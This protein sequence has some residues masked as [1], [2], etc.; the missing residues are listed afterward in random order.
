V[1]V[2][3][4]FQENG[5]AYIVME[6]IE[7]QTFKNYLQRMGGRLP[8]LQVLEMMS[9]V[10]ESLEAVHR[11]G[12]I[13]RDISPDNIMISHD[14]YMKLLDFGAAR[15]FAESGRKTLSVMLKPGF[16]PEEQYRSYGEQGPWTDVYALCAVMYR[17]ITGAMPE[18]STARL[19]QDGLV[20]PARLGA[21]MPPHQEAALLRGMAV[22]RENR[23]QTMGELIRCLE[24]R[25]SPTAAPDAD[26]QARAKKLFLR[27][28]QRANAARCEALLRGMA[29]AGESEQQISARIAGEP[30]HTLKSL[31]APLDNQALAGMLMYGQT[32]SKRGALYPPNLTARPAVEQL[33]AF[34]EA[35]LLRRN[36]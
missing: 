20:P 21:A 10:M 24:D 12:M 33:I 2:R 28:L 17:A 16:S 13:H 29:Q 35:E 25:R 11:A 3:D 36:F 6:F 18:E 14:G 19:R 15:A 22:L 8:A 34:L 30:A 26:A 5:T 32:Q 27:W 7:G 31:S 9:P 1:S 23:I 4:F